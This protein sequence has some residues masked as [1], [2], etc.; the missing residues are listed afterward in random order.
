MEIKQVGEKMSSWR[1]RNGE[2]WGGVSKTKKEKGKRV[3]R[4]GI[5]SFLPHPLPLVRTCLHL[6]VSFSLWAFGWTS[7]M[8]CLVSSLVLVFSLPLCLHCKHVKWTYLSLLI[9]SFASN[10][11]EKSQ[12]KTSFWYVREKGNECSYIKILIKLVHNNSTV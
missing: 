6:L 7:A 11:K 10:G 2:K 12:W 1:A 8:Y 5:D 3:D 4:K 9:V